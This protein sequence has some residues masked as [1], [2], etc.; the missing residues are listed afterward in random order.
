[1]TN[2]IRRHTYGGIHG[3]TIFIKEL[4]AQRCIII[5]D[6]SSESILWIRI[7]DELSGNDLLLGAVYLP[8]EVSDCYH[9]DIFEHLTDDI[10]TIKAKY[11]VPI[12]LLGDF[13]A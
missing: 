3:I 1:M 13:N 12:V 8:H 4:I 2:K 10:I 9:E 5:Q 7:N 11:Q 6:L